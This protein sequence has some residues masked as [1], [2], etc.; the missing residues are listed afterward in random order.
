MTMGPE[1]AAALI[2]TDEW[3]KKYRLQQSIAKQHLTH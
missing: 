1:C 3:A 2:K